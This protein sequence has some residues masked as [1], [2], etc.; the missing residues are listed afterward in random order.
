[1]GGGLDARPS[2]GETPTVAPREHRA[3]PQSI[4]ALA[5]LAAV[6]LPPPPPTPPSVPSTESFSAGSWFEDAYEERL[7]PQIRPWP[8]AGTTV[9]RLGEGSAGWLQVF[10]DG[11][12]VRV[13]LALSGQLKLDAAAPQLAAGTVYATPPPEIAAALKGLGSTFVLEPAFEALGSLPSSR[14]TSVGGEWGWHVGEFSTRGAVVTERSGPDSVRMRGAGGLEV[15]LSAP[16]WHGLRADLAGSLGGV[17]ASEQ[18][19]LVLDL[20]LAR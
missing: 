17:N 10:V 13:P 5:A 3:G 9:W 4:V 15:D 20:H 7:Y 19:A 1:M 16:R 8:A 11:A 12:P 6:A 2:E 18:V 14:L